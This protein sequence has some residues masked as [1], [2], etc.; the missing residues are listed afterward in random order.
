MFGIA[1][2]LASYFG[3][4][5]WL[6]AKG[7]QYIGAAL[8]FPTGALALWITNDQYGF[9]RLVEP[10]YSGIGAIFVFP[11]LIGAL[12]FFPALIIRKLR[13]DLN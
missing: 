13:P 6:G 3:V 1:L 8:L 7:Y 11:F 12:G 2:L 10:G 9:E 4:L 5:A